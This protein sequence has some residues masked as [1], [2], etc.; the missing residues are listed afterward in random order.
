[1]PVAIRQRIAA[2]GRLATAFGRVLADIAL[3]GG[4]VAVLWGGFTWLGA[5][6]DEILG[7]NPQGRILVGQAGP[8]AMLGL[9]SGC[10]STPYVITWVVARVHRNR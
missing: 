10:I 5:S 4:T 7:T 1:M 3:V 6:I 8:F 2:L 9:V